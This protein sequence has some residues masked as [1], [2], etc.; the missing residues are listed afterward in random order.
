MSKVRLGERPFF[1]VQGEGLRTGKLSVWV[2]FFGCTLRC[3]GFY[4]PD[5]TNPSTYHPLNLVNPKEYQRLEDLPTIEYGCDS[6]YSIDSRFKHLAKDYEIG[7]LC[8]ELTSLLHGG[9]WVHPVT[10][11][12]I[13]LCITGG[14]PMLWQKQIIQLL[15]SLRKN[16]YDST[17]YPNHIQIETNA[18]AHMDVEF[19]K[20]FEKND[21]HLHWNISP[22]LFT[23]SGEPSSKAWFPELIRVYH[24]MPFSEGCL[25]FVVNDTDACWKELDEKVKTL[26]NLWV[27]LPVYVMPVGATKEQQENSDVISKIA[28]RAVNSGYHLS[29]RLQAIFWKN[30][31]GT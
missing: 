23:V 24:M 11:N 14:E 18:T 29:S 26:R 19:Y 3:P 10:G 27:D 1:S 8:D 9:K 15:T 6:L 16:P 21:Y 2:R 17:T 20:F 30:T 5:P 31:V 12:D 13:D 4:Q 7:E 28:T 22:K 25:K